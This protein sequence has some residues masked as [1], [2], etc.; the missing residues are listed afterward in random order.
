MSAPTIETASTHAS[1]SPVGTWK[2]LSCFME[3]MET[4]E[5]KAVWGEHPNGWLTMTPAGH[6]TVV[7]TAEG[8]KAPQSEEDRGAAFRSMLAYCGKYRTEGQK[9]IVNVDIAW[10]ESWSGTEQVR[11]FHIEGDRLH[12]EAAPQRYANLGGKIMRAVL[13]WHRAE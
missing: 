1:H 12:I 2:L 10:D 13:I 6:W 3:D 5:E 4:K 9:I 7:Q 8:R 11:Y